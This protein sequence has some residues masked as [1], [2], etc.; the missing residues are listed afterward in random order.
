MRTKSFQ[1]RLEKKLDKQEIDE[2]EKQALLEK[3]VLQKDAKQKTNIVMIIA[4]EA[5]GDLYGSQ[6]AYELRR[7]NSQLKLIGMGGKFMEEANVELLVKSQELAIFGFSDVFKNIPKIYRAFKKIKNAILQKRPDA[8]VLIDYP[9]FNLRLAKVAKKAMVRVVYYVSPQI[10]AWHA[11][12]IKIIKRYVDHMAVILPFEEKIY[13]E[14]KVPVTF[15]GHPLLDIVKTSMSYYDARKKFGLVDAKKIVG[16]M[17][18]SR[19]SEVEHLLPTMLQAASLI[20]EGGN[21]VEFILP[22]APSLKESDLTQYIESTALRIHIVKDC[23]YDAIH[24]CDA[25]IVASGTATLEIALLGVPMVIIYKVSKLNAFLAKKLVK[26]PY[27]GLCNIVLGKMIVKELLQ[28]EANPTAISHEINKIIGYDYY[29]GKMISGLG[30]VRRA[31][32]LKGKVDIARLII[33]D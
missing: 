1:E 10:W 14:A 19:I 33:G 18:G 7:K 30:D 11:S 23:N 16:L 32:E 28:D 6:L 21:D 4:G 8:I 24:I 13:Q 22:L 27:V 9:G 5:S 3:M 12:R 15:V 17:P 2:I 26:I 29:R 25:V 20:K 31:L